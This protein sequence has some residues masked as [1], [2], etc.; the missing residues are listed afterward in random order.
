MLAFF[1]KKGKK[2]LC[3]SQ[4][5]TWGYTCRVEGFQWHLASSTFDLDSTHSSRQLMMEGLKHVENFCNSSF[6]ML[7][8]LNYH[9]SVPRH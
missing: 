2:S 7:S 4:A 8:N 5:Q 1:R 6:I 9:P 3:F